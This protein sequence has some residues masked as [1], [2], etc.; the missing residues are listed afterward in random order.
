MNRSIYFFAFILIFVA[1]AFGQARTKTDPIKVGETAPDFTLND[2]SG[3][4]IHLAELKAPIVLVF[5]R[6][7]WCPFCTRQLADLR[8]LPKA[9]DK[10]RTFAISI[11]P[12]EKSIGL[13]KKIA[14]DG[15]GEIP[16]PFLS[17]P[18]HKTIDDYGLVDTAYEGQDIYGIP[19]P[20]ILI[21]DKDRKVLWVNI[22]LD[23]KHRPTAAEVRSQVDELLKK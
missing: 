12:G 21:L 7:Y 9:D 18:G 5:Y 16:F 6:G 19:H 8:S 3:K 14:S 13:A 20:T 10:F 11:D 22:S 15:K 23:Y 4:S 17:D 2:Q 1:A